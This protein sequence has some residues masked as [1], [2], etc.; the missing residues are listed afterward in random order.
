MALYQQGLAPLILCGGKFSANV[1]Q[2]PQLISPEE[3]AHLVEQGRLDPHEVTQAAQ[4][5]D[6]S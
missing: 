3:L 2:T 6:S 5:W 4:P 1:T